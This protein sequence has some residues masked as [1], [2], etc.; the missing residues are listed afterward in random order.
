M[1]RSILLF[2]FKFYLSEPKN[3]K[4]IGVGLFSKKSF[5]HYMASISGSVYY[6]NMVLIKVLK[7][8][9]NYNSY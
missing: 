3:V 8:G 7:N 5:F 4:T 9:F 1:H 6:D 2:I